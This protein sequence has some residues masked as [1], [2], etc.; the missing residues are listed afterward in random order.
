MTMATPSIHEVADA[1]MAI[2]E[3]GAIPDGDRPV[4]VAAASLAYF[5]GLTARQ[6]T[7]ARLA[8]LDVAMRTLTVAGMCL[9]R[10]VV[11]VLPEAIMPDV[12]AA[13]PTK[14]H[15]RKSFLLPVS[16]LK[17]TARLFGY[18][19][20]WPTSHVWRMLRTAAITHCAARNGLG[21]AI[22]FSGLLSFS[23]LRH[24]DWAQV[25]VGNRGAIIDCQSLLLTPRV[26]VRDAEVILSR[27]T[28]VRR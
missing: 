5:C 20:G 1:F 22:E 21:A 16:D 24:I 23:V 28:N 26:G 3:S 9:K 11:Y 18:A 19:T 14:T 6:M 7:R 10:P 25:P 4:V 15:R 27:R 8:D 13:R 2:A 17:A 12:L